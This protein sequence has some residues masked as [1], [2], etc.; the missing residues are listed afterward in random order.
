MAARRPAPRFDLVFLDPPY[1]AS[2]LAAAVA[3]SETLVG[4][5]T[6]LVVEH[7]K[8][9]PAPPVAGVLERTRELTSGDSALAFYRRRATTSSVVET[10]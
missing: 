3:A 9:D 8:R 5:D 4:D 1:G 10:A 7:A 2:E 6:L